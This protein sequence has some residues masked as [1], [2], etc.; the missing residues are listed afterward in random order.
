MLQSRKDLQTQVTRI[1]QTLEKVLDK[2][3][4]LLEKIH[5]FFKKQGV[6][7]FSILTAFSITITAIVLIMTGVFGGGRSPGGSS[8]KDRDTLK[9]G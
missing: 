9:N 1:N 6:T 7:I 2:D 4:A 3:M 5:I 8:T